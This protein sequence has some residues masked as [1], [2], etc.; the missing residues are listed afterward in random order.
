MTTIYRDGK[1]A[2]QDGQSATNCPYK[3]QGWLRDEWMRGFDAGV[4]G[5][6][7]S[8]VVGSGLEFRR[9]T[10]RRAGRSVSGRL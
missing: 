3:S 8:R 6:R 7:G 4:V 5:F 9:E 1:R 2:G 10:G